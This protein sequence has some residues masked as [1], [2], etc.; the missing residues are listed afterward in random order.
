MDPEVRVFRVE[1]DP[2]RGVRGKMYLCCQK[3]RGGIV[4]KFKMVQRNGTAR[5]S[6]LLDAAEKVD[7]TLDARETSNQGRNGRFADGAEQAKG[8]CARGWM[9]GYGIVNG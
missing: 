5:K 2:H 9:E 1:K 3:P 4:N 7:Q 6:V 8:E